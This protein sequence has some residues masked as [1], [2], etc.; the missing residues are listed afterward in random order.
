MVNY[1]LSCSWNLLG[2][3]FLLSSQNSCLSSQLWSHHGWVCGPQWYCLSKKHHFSQPS[4]PQWHGALR[5]QVQGLT[6]FLYHLLQS[7]T[8]NPRTHRCQC[9]NSRHSPWRGH[10]KFETTAASCI[11]PGM[12]IPSSRQL[13]LPTFTLAWSLGTLLRAS[14]LIQ[15]HS[16]CS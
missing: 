2:D 5:K 10:P 15:S 6:A 3:M 4:S 8:T 16:Q 11:H 9:L 13:Q 14:G 1:T 7:L 12:V